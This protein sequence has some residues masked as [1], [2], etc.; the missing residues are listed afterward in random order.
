MVKVCDPGDGGHEIEPVIVEESDHDAPVPT[1]DASASTTQLEA[2]PNEAAVSP[3]ANFGMGRYDGEHAQ[4]YTLWAHH[5]G[6]VAGVAMI[7]LGFFALVWRRSGTYGCKGLV[8]EDVQARGEAIDSSLIKLGHV[9]NGVNGACTLT[10]SEACCDPTGDASRNSNLGGSY[11]WGAY[12][13]VAGVVVLCLESERGL[14][15]WNPSDTVWYS[16]RVSPLGV[17]IGALGCPTVLTL[18]TALCFVLNT[19]TA[20]VYCK[21][22]WRREAGDGGRS[23]RGHTS[24]KP[25]KSWRARAAKCKAEWE[26]F[27]SSAAAFW[28][29]LY[30]AANVC[31]FMLSFYDWADDVL[32]ME[33]RLLNGRVEVKGCG[34]M[35]EAMIRHG[36]LSRWAPLAKASGVTLNF[37]CALL[38]VPVIK[39]VLWLLNEG[40]ASYGDAQWRAAALGRLFTSLA[41]YVP[42]SRNVEFHKLI[43]STMAMLVLVHSAAHVFNY[44]QSSHFTVF[45][46]ANWGWTGTPFVTGALLLVC[47][48]VIMTG[49]QDNVR[50]AKFEVFWWTHHVAAAFY[51]LL[52][53]HGPVFYLWSVIPVSLY[54]YDKVKRRNRGSTPFVVVRA[55]WATPVLALYFKPLDAGDFDFNEGAFVHLNCPAVSE[56]E[57]HPFTISSARGDLV[58]GTKMI[59]LA[60]GAFVEPVVAEPVARGGD[61]GDAA[62]KSMPYT[63]VPYTPC[64]SPPELR[65]SMRTP[66]GGSAGSSPPRGQSP[67]RPRHDASGQQLYRPAA[68][69][70]GAIATPAGGKAARRALF[71]QHEVAYHDFISCHIK[72]V[73]GRGA[74]TWTSKFK[75][76]LELMAPGGAYPIHFSRR[77]ARGDVHLG[78]HLGPD[79]RPILRVDG[80]H[81]AP[82]THYKHYGTV[83]VVGAGIG[84]TPCAAILTALVRYRW[85]NNFKPEV[86]HVYWLVQHADLAGFK[87]FIRLLADLEAELLCA[88]ESGTVVSRNHIEIHAFVTRAPAPSAESPLLQKD[89][90]SSK[91]DDDDSSEGAGAAHRLFTVDAL[92]DELRAPSAGAADLVATMADKGARNRFQDIWVWRGRPCWD[93]AFAA[94]RAPRQHVGVVFCG[95]PAIGNDLAAMAKKHSAAGDGCTFTLHRER[96]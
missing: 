33:R 86:V 23:G 2:G 88:R 56:H 76:Y 17:L 19:L 62:G 22:A 43:A 25:R 77:D 39:T 96:F 93:A 89:A 5:M 67:Q 72:V 54:V 69:A 11:I 36:P 58:A 18:A 66:L 30:Y 37:N 52:L 79:S 21:A 73:E 95:P 35:N 75:A 44:R 85:R 70:G 24:A 50:I 46:F 82:A 68:R 53:L 71:E 65:A 9:V 14:G 91:S 81:A 83:M 51:G 1:S 12:T 40:A 7:A 27:M 92:F 29:F 94:V 32:E 78:R 31:I 74:P 3:E 49:A 47:M 8:E 90:S 28:V 38:I 20:L 42:V 41:R 45:R 48:F 80:P 61:G 87:W 55:E 63:R 13:M 4:Q 57:W 84:V 10:L 60:T 59:S 15:L 34:Q 16:R 64:R 26:A 6:R